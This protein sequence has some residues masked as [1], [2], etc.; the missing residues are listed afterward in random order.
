MAEMTYISL[1]SKQQLL[2]AVQRSSLQQF[3]VKKISF[4]PEKLSIS[5]NKLNQF[6]WNNNSLVNLA[7][8]IFSDIADTIAAIQAL[9]CFV[10]VNFAL[11]DTVLTAGVQNK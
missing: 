6:N 10:T 3:K 8:F 9:K 4:V 5:S 1:N 7:L 2:A 11:S